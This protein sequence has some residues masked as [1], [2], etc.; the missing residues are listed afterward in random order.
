MKASTAQQTTGMKLG[1]VVGES[2][3]KPGRQNDIEAQDD[4]LSTQEEGV[5]QQALDR[6][7]SYDDYKRVCIGLRGTAMLFD[8]LVVLLGA[9]VSLV[10]LLCLAGLIKTDVNA[11]LTCALNVVLAFCKLLGFY[12]YT[13][14]ADRYMRLV[15]KLQPLLEVLRKY[16]EDFEKYCSSAINLAEL[17]LSRDAASEAV[18]S[19]DREVQQAALVGASRGLS[20]SG[21]VHVCLLSIA[22]CTNSPC[23]GLQDGLEETTQPADDPMPVCLFEGYRLNF[24]QLVCIQPPP[25]KLVLYA[26]SSMQDL[27]EQDRTMTDR[28]RGLEDCKAILVKHSHPVARSY[29]QW[30]DGE[31]EY[32]DVVRTPTSLLFLHC[33]AD[34]ASAGA[35][36]RVDSAKAVAIKAELDTF[37]K[38]LSGWADAHNNELCCHLKVLILSWQDFKRR[39]QGVAAKHAAAG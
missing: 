28:L 23:C 7:D 4:K 22:S 1:F 5:N 32:F 14:V 2:V 10:S 6:L 31:Q 39:Q 24:L 20:L 3:R 38:R 26:A 9:L 21:V 8:F 15:L 25:G 13:K 35:P 30:Q 18:A 33:G 29:H 12:K 11:A 19:F 37:A 16:H 17:S 36:G 34:T 27:W